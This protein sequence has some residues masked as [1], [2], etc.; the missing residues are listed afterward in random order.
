LAFLKEMFS[1]ASEYTHYNGIILGVMQYIDDSADVWLKLIMSIIMLVYS[2]SYLT[3]VS[4]F[5]SKIN[6]ADTSFLG[7]LSCLLCFYPFTI[8]TSQVI[9]MLASQEIPFENLPAKL[10]LSV[11][12][13]IAMLISLIAIFRLGGRAGNLTNRGIVTGFPY[14]I[15]R[16]PDY[17]MQIIY[18]LALTYPLFLS[19][20]LPLVGKFFYLLGNLIWIYLYYL[21]AITEERNLVKD[22]VYKEYIKKVKY[23]FLPKIF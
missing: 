7:V 8:F 11:I 5:K 15:V 3:D 10:G 17:S 1:Q 19:K 23:R 16:H 22:E 12:M 9:P 4:F 6:Y 18:I 13:I 20:E 21:R 14:N 2:F